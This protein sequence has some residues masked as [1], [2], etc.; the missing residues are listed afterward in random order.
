MRMQ[1]PERICYQDQGKNRDGGH[2]MAGF[3]SINARYAVKLARARLETSAA[4]RRD[5][6]ARGSMDAT[7]CKRAGTGPLDAPHGDGAAGLPTR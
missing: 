7:R 2:P 3:L 4:S 5:Q 6:S 1:E